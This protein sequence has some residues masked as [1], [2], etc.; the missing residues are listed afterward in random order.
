MFMFLMN[1]LE[2]AL[3]TLPQIWQKL[4]LRT[5]ISTNIQHSINLLSVHLDFFLSSL[6]FSPSVLSASFPTT[7]STSVFCSWDSPGKNSGVGSHLILQGIF[8]IRGSNPSLL[9]CRWILYCWATE[10]TLH[11]G[12]QILPCCEGYLARM[13]ISC[14]TLLSLF[15]KKVDAI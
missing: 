10:E 7:W 6:L 14:L 9:H 4:I 11:I 12:N 3:V 1:R 5:Q 13:L 2:L 15:F 8:L